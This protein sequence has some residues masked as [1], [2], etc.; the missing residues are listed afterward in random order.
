MNRGG[1]VCVRGCSSSN[2]RRLGTVIQVKFD[3]DA[4]NMLFD[5]TFADRELGGDLLVRRTLS[6]VT[7]H[8]QFSLAE[9][10]RGRWFLRMRWQMPW[11]FSDHFGRH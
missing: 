4:M 8:L 7:Q 11:K 9:S 2:D 1:A 3:E 6:Q 10:Y 5:R